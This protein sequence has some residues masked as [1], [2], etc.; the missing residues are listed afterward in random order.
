[1]QSALL[2]STAFLIS[3]QLLQVHLT[4]ISISKIQQQ[5][6]ESLSL[7]PNCFGFYKKSSSFIAVSQGTRTTS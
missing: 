3:L 1:M 4:V 2:L 5:A 7:E 6:S